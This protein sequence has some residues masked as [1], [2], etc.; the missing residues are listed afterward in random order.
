MFETQL[1]VRDV[2][3]SMRALAYD[4]AGLPFVQGFNVRNA[5]STAEASLTT[6]TNTSL[7]AAVTGRFMDLVELSFANNSAT[8]SVAIKDD[9]TTVRT[10][11]LP[12]SNTVQY[13]FDPPIPQGSLGSIWSADMEDIT[14]TTVSV[15]ALFKIN[16]P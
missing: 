15:G 6:G 14:G 16:R 3:G 1:V 7:Q 5:Y 13:R 10:F 2:E 4:A 9:G 11:Q 8:A 12:A